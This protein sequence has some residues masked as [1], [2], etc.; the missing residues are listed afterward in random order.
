MLDSQ[1]FDLAKAKERATAVIK[2]PEITTI[3]EEKGLID[4]LLDEIER[5]EAEDKHKDIE[6]EGLNQNRV[7]WSERCLKAE[8]E[9][10]AKDVDIAALTAALAGSEKNIVIHSSED[11]ARIQELEA[12]LA[13]ERLWWSFTIHPEGCGMVALGEQRKQFETEG[14]TLDPRWKQEE[15]QGC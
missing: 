6:I 5:L 7:E 12:K 11:K 4:F 15:L 14:K 10:A 13:N 1:P 8:S 3:W 2:N 9:I